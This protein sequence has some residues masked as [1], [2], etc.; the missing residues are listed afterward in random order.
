MESIVIMIANGGKRISTTKIGTE[1]SLVTR[2]GGKEGEGALNASKPS[3]VFARNWKSMS[4]PNCLGRFVPDTEQ[5][6]T[7]QSD[8]TSSA[9]LDAE[10]EMSKPGES[11][12]QYMVR[13]T[14]FGA[15]TEINVQLG[16]FI[17]RR[18]RL[19]PI[20]SDILENEDFATIFGSYDTDTEPLQCAE[21]MNTS[22]RI[23]VRIV[24]RRHDLQFWCKDS[25]RVMI[26][27]F[28]RAYPSSLSSS[29]SEDWIKS[30]FEP[31]R[32]SHFPLGDPMEFKMPSLDY[33]NRMVAHMA[34]FCPLID[35]FEDP[36][37]E[38]DY[39]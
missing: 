1:S 27:P 36:K 3:T 31:I 21:V 20:R 12:E 9:S 29:G 19:E 4:R 23:W 15:E 6:S 13:K 22:H 7:T 30:V 11:Y 28:T 35:Q 24:G 32:Q 5:A 14:N 10:K 38:E 39:G 16:E 18:H 33:S 37:A 17:L 26:N 8:G 34:V 2:E 25:S